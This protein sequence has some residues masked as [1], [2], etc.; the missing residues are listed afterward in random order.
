MTTNH[1][2]HC[3]LSLC[4]LSLFT[5]GLIYHAAHQPIYMENTFNVRRQ[6]RRLQMRQSSKTYGTHVLYIKGFLAE[7]CSIS[8][9]YT[10]VETQIN[11]SLCLVLAL[12]A[13]SAPIFPFYLWKQSGKRE[14]ERRVFISE[15]SSTQLRTCSPAGHANDPQTE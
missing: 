1:G 9:R 5:L 8:Q 7:Q 6:T 4:I 13:C 12:H 2:R 11:A 14:R 15:S 3:F 10:L